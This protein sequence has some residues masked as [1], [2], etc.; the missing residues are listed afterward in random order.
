[1]LLRNATLLLGITLASSVT[2]SRAD[3]QLPGRRCLSIAETVVKANERFGTFDTL[4]SALTT[5]DLVGTLDQG[6]PFTV[7]APTDRAF[8]KLEV[9]L[10]IPVG[11]IPLDVVSNVL[12][13]HVSEGFN[14]RLRGGVTTLNGQ[15]IKVKKRGP[16]LVLEDPNGRESRVLIRS[17]PACNGVI[18]VID[19]VLLPAAS[20]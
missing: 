19:T 8:A 7:F 5:A 18:Y 17:I 10:G 2:I 15:M 6:G 14:F 13:T 16:F 9:E 4:L 20:P 11:S 12:L 3:A 1:M